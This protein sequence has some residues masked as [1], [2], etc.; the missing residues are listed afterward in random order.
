MLQRSS[1]K[2]PAYQRAPPSRLVPIARGIV[3]RVSQDVVLSIPKQPRYADRHLLDMARGQDC[4]LQSP[5]CNHNPETTVA[6]H[7]GGVSSG[8]GMGYKTGDDLTV[9]GCDACNYFTDAYGGASAEEKAEVF[10]AGHARQVALW[11]EIAVS[12]AAPARDRESAKAVLLF[13][14]LNANILVN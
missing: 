4:L 3:T 6:C 9:F 2:R 8:K 10:A 7:A 12:R 5:L 13:L 14:G 1:F 11:R